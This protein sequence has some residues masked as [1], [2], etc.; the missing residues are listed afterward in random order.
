MSLLQRKSAARF[1]CQCLLGE[2]DLWIHKMMEGRPG[3]NRIKALV[4]EGKFFRHVFHKGEIAEA[5]LIRFLPSRHGRCQVKTGHMAA[6]GSKCPP[7]E[8][9]AATFTTG[10]AGFG[11]VRYTR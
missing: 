8:V 2:D 6:P 10:S 3:D 4:Q 5:L 9:P 1:Q 11:S 7:A